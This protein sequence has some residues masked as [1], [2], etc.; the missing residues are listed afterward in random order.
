MLAVP[1]AIAPAYAEPASPVRSATAITQ[2]F[3]DGQKLTAVAVEYDRDI[4]DSLL[5]TSAFQVAGR[6]VTRV[7]ATKEPA[8]ARSGRNGRYVIVELSA[9]D[10]SAALWVTGQG[11]GGGTGGPPTV[12]DSTPGGTILPATASVTQTGTVTTTGGARYE[13]TGTALATTR[14]VNPIVD[15]FEQRS[16]TDPA[17]G[18]TLGYNLFVPRNYDR[19]KRYPLVLFMHDA[20]VVN[21]ATEGPLVQGLGAVCWASEEDQR[22]HECFVLAPEYGSVVVDDNYQP[23]TLFDATVNLVHA[24]TT[25]YSLDRGRL[26]ATGQ[27]MGAMMALGMNIKYPK[28]FAASYIVAGQWPAE[29]AL[30]LAG[31]KLWIVVSQGDT[32]A[33]PGE[34]AI[35]E[36]IEGAGTEVSRATWDGGATPAQF[37][38]DVRAME[39]SRAP[40]NYASFTAGTV[41]PPGS[42]GGSEHTSTWR[43]AYTIPGIREWI[44]RQSG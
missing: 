34:N 10:E 14:V 3:G 23:S 16:F 19:H 44:L 26:Y 31:K 35:T 7:Y 18:Q 39:A 24:L 17:T 22:E 1:G 40:V 27:S 15:D 4:V 33:Y 36:V 28:L 32:K 30:P 41:T 6:T 5:T 29:Q 42:A 13:A 11:S 21:V 9:E 43:V 20:S 37:A 25:E 12:G 8:V 2:V 38:S